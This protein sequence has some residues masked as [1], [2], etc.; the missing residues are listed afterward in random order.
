MNQ[1]LKTSERLKKKSDYLKV[2][3]GK[4]C[5]GRLITVYWRI[6]DCEESRFGFITGKKVSKRAVDRNRLRRYFKE[7]CRRN[8]ALFP[9]GTD[10]VF[11]AMPGAGKA[12]YDEI[13]NEAHRLMEKIASEIPADRTD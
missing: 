2:L 1:R 3:R 13:Y 8:K 5:A 12:S 7:F 10:F 6:C 9:A 4:R 11:R